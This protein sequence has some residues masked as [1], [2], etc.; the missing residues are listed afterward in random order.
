VNAH[1]VLRREEHILG[2]AALQAHGIVAPDFHHAE[3]TPVIWDPV[4]NGEIVTDVQNA[5][6]QK[7]KH[8]YAFHA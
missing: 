6:R 2:L 7:R 4:P 8:D 1:L 5:Q 3:L